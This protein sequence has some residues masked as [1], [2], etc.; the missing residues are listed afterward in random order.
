MVSDLAFRLGV[1]YAYGFILEYVNGVVT[2]RVSGDVLDKGGKGCVLKRILE[3]EGLKEDSCVVVADD[4][5]NLSMMLP[6]ALKIGFNPD[7]LVRV[8]A[9]Y[10]VTGSLE[11][12]L[13]LIGVE[14]PRGRGLPSR[15]EVLR[16][17]IHA[18]G[19]TVP[20]LQGFLGLYGVVFLILV[21]TLLYSFSMVAV[22]RGRNVPLFSSVI[23]RAASAGETH[24]FA[25]AP[26]YF[27]LGISAAILVFPGNAGKA[28][29]AIFAFGDSAASIF[30]RFGSILLPFNKGKT[31]EG[32]TAGLLFGFLGALFFVSPLHGL[33]AAALAM[34]V[35]CLP[36]PISDNITVPLTAG[37]LL[38]FALG[39]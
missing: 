34:I 27:A 39:S 23:R 2:G 14:K 36:S 28:A 10:V 30:G 24:G 29:V 9:D 16:E 38:K 11:E 15:N 37:A 33:A 12:I 31:L 32:F 1:D 13:S 35:E 4:R 26:V 5:N 20:F 7:F 22:L 3:R 8:K 17:A 6:H 18:C 21:V 19:F 25:L